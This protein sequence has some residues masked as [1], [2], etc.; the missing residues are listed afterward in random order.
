MWSNQLQNSSWRNQD[1][2]FELKEKTFFVFTP[3]S[4]T[5]GTY[6]IIENSDFTIPFQGRELKKYC[7]IK[8]VQVNFVVDTVLIKHCVYYEIYLNS[9]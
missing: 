1:M 4:Y 2:W 3:V 5:V 7:Y 9:L 8:T 6:N